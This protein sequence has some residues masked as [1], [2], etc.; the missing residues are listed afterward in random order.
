MGS[1]HG[2]RTMGTALVVEAFR[3]AGARRFPLRDPDGDFVW[4]RPVA[5]FR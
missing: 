4:G 2:T 3:K 1:F 5:S